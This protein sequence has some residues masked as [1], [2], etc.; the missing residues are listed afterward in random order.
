MSVCLSVQVHTFASPSSLCHHL[1]SV[2]D[3]S[4]ATF[5][6]SSS[7]WNLTRHTTICA[8]LSNRCSH[9]RHQSWYA[10]VLL[11]I[12]SLYRADYHSGCESVWP[13][14]RSSRSGRRQQ[15]Q[16]GPEG[17]FA[18]AYPLHHPCS[19]TPRRISP[20]TSLRHSPPL[21]SAARRESRP[22]PTPPQNFQTSTL[23]PAA[24]SD[25]CACNASTTICY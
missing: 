6:C 16:E 15:G 12:S 18:S 11:S 10:S 25:T 3:T 20:S 14:R 21:A 1:I 22:V 9:I 7:P 24:S 13:W 19:H 4:L 23:P 2:D 17:T 5:R 8:P